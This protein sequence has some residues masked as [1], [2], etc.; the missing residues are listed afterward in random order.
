MLVTRPTFARDIAKLFVRAAI[1][2]PVGDSQ[3]R[4]E[5]YRNQGAIRRVHFPTKSCEFEGRERKI[6]SMF[7]SDQARNLYSM[8]F[9]SV[10]RY[11]FFFNRAKW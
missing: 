8:K 1:S 5:K 9:S 3:T 6:E 11:V 10:T 2:S 7:E 4:T